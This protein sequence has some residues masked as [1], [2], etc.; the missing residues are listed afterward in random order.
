[1]PPI[2]RKFLVPQRIQVPHQKAL[3]QPEV[4]EMVEIYKSTLSLK[5][6]ERAKEKEELN[7]IESEQRAAAPSNTSASMKAQCIASLGPD[8]YQRMYQCFIQAQ[9]HDQPFPVLMDKI[10]HLVNNDKEKINKAFLIEQIIEAQR[11]KLK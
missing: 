5:T 8:L 2:P 11:L 10:K 7:K 9:E 6:E 4:Q 1:M 3:R